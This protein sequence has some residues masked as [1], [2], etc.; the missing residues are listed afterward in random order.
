MPNVAT[1]EGYAVPQVQ[2]RFREDG[3][4]K[5]TDSAQLFKA[6]TVAV[7]SLPGAFTP[8]CSNSHLPRFNELA[9]TFRANGVD[10]IV[11]ISVNDPFVM[12]E[13]SRSQ[14]CDEVFLLPDGNGTFTEA[15]GMLVDKSELNFGKRSRRYSMLVRDG[16]V[17]RM[18]VEPDE[19]GDPF[20]V[21]DADTLLRHV[22]RNA[23]LPDQVALLTKEG[24]AFCAKARKLLDDAGV[25]F[26]EVGLA[27]NI[28][29][30][31]LGAIARASTVPQLFVNGELIGDSGAIAEWLKGRQ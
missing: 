18:F 20:T 24:C 1:R 9:P 15:M 26:A 11:C 2:F 27:R 28:R 23:V 4:W 5:Q 10:R 8:T 13:W 14:E 31:A 16:I 3:E 30:R 22:N 17:D 29:S 12:E 19:P 6:Q 21:S 25:R 7:F